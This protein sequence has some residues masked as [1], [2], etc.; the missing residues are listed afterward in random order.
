[1]AEVTIHWSDAVQPGD[2]SA[3]FGMSDEEA[4]RMLAAIAT[5]SVAEFTVDSSG[6]LI[7]TLIDS[8]TQV[9]LGKVVGDKGD[10]GEQGDPGPRGPGGGTPGRLISVT[11]P[12]SGWKGTSQQV[13]VTGLPT[14]TDVVLVRPKSRSD[15]GIW[16]A[17]Q[18]WC[19]VSNGV[20]TAVCG[21]VAPTRDLSVEVLWWENPP[22]QQV[23]TVNPSAF[24]DSL[25]AQVTVEGVGFLVTS[26]SP[27]RQSDVAQWVAANLWVTRSTSDVLTITAQSLPALPVKMLVTTW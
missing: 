15:A 6:H 22:S 2:V 18:V 21:D 1:M 4:E 23:I 25:V 19:S 13:T 16:G 7:A 27:A 24:D 8:D 10:K 3:L 17:S 14:T 20:L 11:L 5:D 26:V 9:D 12:A